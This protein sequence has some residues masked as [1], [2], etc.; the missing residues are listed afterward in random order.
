MKIFRTKTVAVKLITFSEAIKIHMVSNK[1]HYPAKECLT[2]VRYN[3]S[4]AR[5]SSRTSRTYAYVEEM[6]GRSVIE[7]CHLLKKDK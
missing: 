6:A 7:V 4:A 3:F 2:R 5:M 1:K